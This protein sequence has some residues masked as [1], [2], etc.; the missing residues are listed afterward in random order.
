MK[1]FSCQNIKIPLKRV[2]THSHGIHTHSHDM[3]GVCVLCMHVCMH[4]HVCNI[5]IYVF[6]QDNIWPASKKNILDCHLTRHR[7]EHFVWIH[8]CIQF[9]IRKKEMST[10]EGS[11]M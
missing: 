1:V 5:Y 4:A 3:Y 6:V 11:W 2:Y 8:K 9:Q 7:H 10:K